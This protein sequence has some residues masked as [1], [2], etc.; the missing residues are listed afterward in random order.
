MLKAQSMRIANNIHPVTAIEIEYS[1]ACRFIETEILPLATE[2]GIGVIPYRV[3]AEG[4]LSGTAKQFVSNNHGATTSRNHM[5]PPRLEGGNY[6]HNMM[7]AEKLKPIAT[8]KKVTTAQ[9]AVA[10]LLAQGENIVPLVG[11]SS[12]VRLAENLAILDISFTE[13][14][15]KYLDETFSQDA[16][17]GDR[18]PALVMPLVPR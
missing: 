9:L 5:A 1:L 10:W 13:E 8:E 11:M 6:L 16:I 17:W 7:V 18:Y 15:L 2:L 4:I 12:V 3:L 14:E